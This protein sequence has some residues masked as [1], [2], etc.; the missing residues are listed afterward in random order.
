MSSQQAIDEVWRRCLALVGEWRG[1]GTGEAGAGEGSFIFEP[2]LDG[3]VIERRGR[4]AYPTFT[5][6]DR[7]L[8]RRDSSGVRALYIDN[9]GHEIA[10][11]VEPSGE[12]IAFVSDGALRFRL[13][14]EPIGA[15]RVLVAFEIARDGEE[16]R[17][18]VAGE[19]TRVGAGAGAGDPAA[20]HARMV[21]LLVERGAIHDGRVE[22][23][24]RAVPRH[25]F[26]PHAPLAPV[27]EGQV[28]VLRRDERGEPTVTASEPGIM[29]L[30]LEQLRLAPGQRVLEIGAGSGYNAAL[31]TWLVR[32]EGEVTTIELEADVAADAASRLVEAGFSEVRVIAGDGWLGAPERA[33]FD[34]VESTASVEDLSPHWVAQLAEGGLLL[35]PL[36]LRAGQAIVAFRK[37]GERLVSES[38]RGGGFIPLRGRPIE[39]PDGRVTVVAHPWSLTVHG[40]PDVSLRA[41]AK[42]LRTEPRR[43][44]GL[45]LAWGTW[46]LLGLE[47]RFPITLVDQRGA[48]PEGPPPRAM[49]G[50]LDPEGPS[51]AA[52]DGETLLVFGADDAGERLRAWRTRFRVDRWRIEAIPMERSVVA[53]EGR[54]LRRKHYQFI[55]REEA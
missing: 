35:V 17:T 50:V 46:W 24:F 16:F 21:D 27:Y 30:M 37:N 8:I 36:R 15:D 6:E 2:I 39:T 40:D 25:F 4:T 47:E 32:P 54:V 38:M 43:E 31:L 10:Y 12:G 13:R 5:H 18:H 42:L 11:R 23:A 29:A 1:G 48:K 22:A 41:L 14:Y 51:L 33:P 45:T 34:R 9:E 3:K 20:L 28:I 55:V 7:M 52:T 53:A 44:A 26:A 19:A 49:L